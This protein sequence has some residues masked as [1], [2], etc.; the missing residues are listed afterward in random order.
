VQEFPGHV[1]VLL[2]HGYPTIPIYHFPDVL[3]VHLPLR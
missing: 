1:P 2:S 3:I